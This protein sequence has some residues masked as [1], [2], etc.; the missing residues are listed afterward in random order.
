MWIDLLEP[1]PEEE[2]TVEKFLGIEVPTREEMREIETSNRLYEEGGGLYMT[3]TVITK[4]DT[5]T[6][7]TSQ[8]T[9]ILAGNRLITNRYVDTLPFRRYTAYAERHPQQCASGAAV[10]A[11]LLEATVN[12]IAD[13][14]ERVGANLDAISLEVF[15]P[16][17]RRGPARDFRDIL[18]RVGQNGDMV[19]KARESLASLGRL[20]VFAQQATTT[21]ITADVRSRLRTV[22]RDATQMADHAS[23]LG[24]KVNFILDATLG[25]INIDQNNILK[26]FS[27]VTVFLLPP[28][29]IG[30]I[31]GMNFTHIPA[32]TQPWGFAAALGLMVISAVIP[33]LI[34]KQRRWL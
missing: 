8:V 12:R 6:P 1:T 3:T 2:L 11:G 14:I 24:N 28:S 25:M 16:P 26:I 5:A 9:Y 31:F 30:A 13:V 18:A 22:A 27:V 34:F 32:A 4:I 20:L 10:L 15:T 7:E 19:G 21:A 29:V 33:W 17:Q 23:F